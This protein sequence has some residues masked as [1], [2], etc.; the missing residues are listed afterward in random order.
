MIGDTDCKINLSD[1]LMKKF[2][3]CLPVVWVIV[4]LASCNRQTDRVDSILER[5][6]NIVEQYP[7]SALLL[8]DSI[9][10]P[11]ELNKS[12]FA[13]YMLRSVQAKDKAY[14]DITSETLIFE[15]RDY[16]KKEKD[17]EKLAL[18]EFYCG[19][20]LQ[21]QEKY[22][23]AMKS[24]LEAETTAEKNKDPYLIGMA[25]FFMG[26]LCDDQLL[27]DEAMLHYKKAKENFATLQ[28]KYKHTMMVYTRIAFAYVLEELPDSAFLYY[29]KGLEIA[30]KNNDLDGLSMIYQNMG[31]TFSHIGK[32]KEARDAILHA[33]SLHSQNSGASPGPKLLLNMA[34]VY[35]QENNMDSA[36]HYANASLKLSEDTMTSIKSS[37]YYLMSDIE[38]SAGNYKKSLEYYEIYSD[39]LLDI[40]REKKDPAFLE[41]QKK[42]NFELIGNA[43]RKLVIER[44]WLSIAFILFAVLAFFIFYKNRIKNRDAL[45]LA[46]QQIYQ[47]KEMVVEKDRAIGENNN[48]EKNK[49]LRRTLFKQLDILKKISLLEGYL[50]KEEKKVGKTILKKVNGIIY[51]SNNKFDWSIFYQSVNALYDDF[52]LRLASSYPDLT[53]DEI[54]ICCLSKIGL[55][56]EEINLL[57]K[58]T[59]NVIQKRKSSIREKTGMRKQEHFI[60]QLDDIIKNN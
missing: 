32:T 34:K 48:D 47:L 28:N 23:E 18:S 49:V 51:E 26:D 52:L 37:I 13:H 39:L 33:I 12:Q 8:L 59:T 46:K 2:I 1:Q 29:K 22:K 44:L 43:N 30:E 20:V 5:A 6:A 14:K 17:Q 45:M 4:M 50:D 42:Y 53:E 15:I 56:N 31:V 25:N 41:V 19:R 9:P 3:S 11:Y 35:Y 36:L 55:S 10:N 38:K 58:S 21:S 7:D 40:L 54:L 24:F 27:N 16:Y 60:K 57:L